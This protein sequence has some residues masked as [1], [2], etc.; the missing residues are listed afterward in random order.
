[1]IERTL[2]DA[3]KHVDARD[4]EVSSLR[5]ELKAAAAELKAARANEAGATPMRTKLRTSPA[6]FPRGPKKP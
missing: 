2:A 4:Q 5:Q 6:V 3:Q 1:M